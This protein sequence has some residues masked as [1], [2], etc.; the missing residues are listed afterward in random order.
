[1]SQ[2]KLEKFLEFFAKEGFLKK[3]PGRPLEKP[4]GP[5]SEIFAKLPISEHPPKSGNF[6]NNVVEEG[7][8]KICHVVLRGNE[9]CAGYDDKQRYGCER[10]PDHV[11]KEGSK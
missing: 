4:S 2:A 3:G 6:T 5:H 1:M 11:R 9:V 10:C 7:F 8:I